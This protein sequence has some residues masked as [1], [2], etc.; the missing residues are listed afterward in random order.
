MDKLFYERRIAE[1]ELK[2]HNLNS[3]GTEKPISGEIHPYRFLFEQSLDG[4]AFCQMIFEENIPVDFIYLDVNPAFYKLS[5][6]KNV[7]GHKVSEFLPNL[8]EENPEV[9]NAY[10]SVAMGG[11]PIRLETFVQSLDIW[12]TIS[13]TSP[14]KGF[15]IAV[16]DDITPQKRAEEALKQSEENYRLMFQNMFSGFQLNEVITDENN[17]PVDFRFLDGNSKMEKFTGLNIEDVRGKTI[18]EVIPDA[19]PEMIKK[20]GLVGLTGKPF[21]SELFSETFNKHFL[22]SAY[23]PKKGLFAVVFE[24]ITQKVKSDLSITSQN[25]LLSKLNRFAIALSNLSFDDNLE[26]FIAKQAKELT[27]AIFTVFSEYDSA[28]KSTTPKHIELESRFLT[29]VVSLVGGNVNKI[30]SVVT[31]EMYNEM[32]SD[33]VGVR[34]TLHEVSFGAISSTV[35]AAI[36]KMLNIDRFIG[37]VYMIEGKMYGTSILAMPK[38]KPDPPREILENFIHLAADAL[39]KKLKE[40][41]LR[42]SAVK[43]RSLILN[44]PGAVYHRRIKLSE[45]PRRL[46]SMRTVFAD[47]ESVMH[48]LN[49]ITIEFISDGIKTITGYSATEFTEQK[50][51]FGDLIHPD[52]FSKAPDI[53]L[54]PGKVSKEYEL[55]YRIKHRDGNWHWILERGIP[56]LDNDTKS[57]ILN[58]ILFDISDHKNIELQLEQYAFT[59]QELIQFAFIASHQLQEPIRT[60]SNYAHVIEEDYSE[61]LGENGLKYLNTIKDATKRML[62]LMDTL[63][64]FSQL[65]RNRKLV[66][67]DCKQL[68]YGVIRDLEYLVTTSEAVIEI[69]DMPALNLYEVE[70]RQLFQNL[71]INA[72][73]FQ[74]KNNKPKIQIRSEKLSD[75]WRFSVSDNGIGIE[76]D[77]SERIFDIFQRLHLNEEEYEGKG[78]GLAYCKK[79]VQMHHGDIWVESSPGKGSTFYFTISELTT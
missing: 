19:D 58:G 57:L 38:D 55:E 30:H 28:T 20:Y 12:V 5:G 40:K 62:L 17:I 68:I 45:K 32:S 36:E 78:I 24:D 18:R 6:L 52:D 10:G 69:G 22:I 2:L 4:F 41:A 63:L 15:F 23:S 74:S 3:N 35:G 42:E 47:H 43:Y 61:I 72:I 7:I 39:Q 56:Y 64:E 70:I 48:F 79:I 33:L 53:I 60:V 73:K 26:A 66:Y 25:I 34:K 16:F 54:Y 77:Q 50:I 8:K 71:I 51:R 59:N 1:L 27:G 46:K 14:M 21:T 13:V 67:I 37:I 29:K 76:T 44:I 31:D 11:N 9:L 49:D 75:K 65:G